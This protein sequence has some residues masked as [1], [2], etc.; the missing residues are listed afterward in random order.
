MPQETMTPRERWLAVLTRQTP[1][2]VPMDYWATPEATTKLLQHLDCTY[3]E[4]LQRLHID[5]PFNVGGHYVGPQPPE[6]EDIWGLRYQTVTY[7]GGAYSEVINA[8]LAQYETVEEIEARY[9][10]PSPD[11][12][13]YSHLPAALEGQ[14]HRPICGGGSEPF[15]IYKHLRGDEQ[16]FMD[17]VENPEIVDYCLGRMFELAYQSTLRIFETIPGQ[18]MISYVAE[19]LGAQQS[20]MISRDTIRRFLLP[21]MKRMMEL[22]HQHGS[23]VFNHDDGAI[24]DI[25]PDFIEAGIDVLNPIQWR[26]PGM[27]REGLKRDF[28]DQIVFHGAMDN[29]VTLP[30]G[31]TAE[32]RREVRENLEILG[33]GGGYI[34]APCHNIQ[35]VSPPENIVAMYEAGYE[36]GQL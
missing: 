21:H 20:L 23:F 1:D 28:G 16:A 17:L 14:G 24:R 4:M 8:P 30:W 29:Q 33:A 13:D 7:E 32:V 11:D 9:H 22:V 27:D 12:W 25:I 15:L 26:L 34:L 6:G 35:A 10:W 2:R 5:V 36:M 3:E 18:V 19:D 31:T